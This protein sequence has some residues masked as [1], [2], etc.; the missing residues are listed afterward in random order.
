MIKFIEKNDF[1]DR[2]VALFGTSGGGEGKE[3]EFME[4]VLKEKNVNVKGKYF[5]Q[6][7]FWFGNKDKPSKKDLDDSMKFARDMIK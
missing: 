2:D 3:T 7:K 5:C 4:T 6:G 1:T